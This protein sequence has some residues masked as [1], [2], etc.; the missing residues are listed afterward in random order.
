[1]DANG[2]GVDAN[3][4]DESGQLCNL[5]WADGISRRNFA[6]FGDVMSF[7]ATY[8]TNKNCQ[9]LHKPNP[10]LMQLRSVSLYKAAVP[11][12]HPLAETTYPSANTELA[13]N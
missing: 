7:D 12:L 5:F 3:N 1:M 2:G 6:C 11:L 10:Q 13:A 8:R 9:V 4:P